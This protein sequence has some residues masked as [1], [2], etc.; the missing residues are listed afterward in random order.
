MSETP[1][2]ETPPKTRRKRWW[3]L[4]ALALLVLAAAAGWWWTSR[5]PLSDEER[6]L[7]GT[8]TV[9]MDGVPMDT[10]LQYEFR[11]DR[12]CLMRNV[13]AA[14]GAVTA[15]IPGQTW[16]LSDGRLVVRHPDGAA[17]SFWHVLPSQRA[18]DEVW[19][20]T[21]DGP[22]RFRY[23]GTIEIRSTPQG[24]PVTGTVTRV[25]PRE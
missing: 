4:S 23:Q 11:P 20:L 15:D 5:T 9:R 2:A 18:M 14:T 13:D 8:W 7:I 1:R 24:P 22:D 3:V 16:S 25:T 6:H 19:L 10:L 12:T 21:P 17:G